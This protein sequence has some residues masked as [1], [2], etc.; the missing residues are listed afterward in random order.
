MDG[1]DITSTTKI[2]N[3]WI[4]DFAESINSIK[5]NTQ[6]AIAK[7]F[8]NEINKPIYL[9]PYDPHSQFHLSKIHI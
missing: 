6:K 2:E 9:P 4:Y 1:I 5:D 7:E 8:N 3:E